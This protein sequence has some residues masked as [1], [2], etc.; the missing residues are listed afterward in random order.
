MSKNFLVILMAVVLLIS[1]SSEKKLARKASNAVSNTDYEKAI[2][3]YDE[4]LSKNKDSYIGNAGKGIVLSEYYEKHAQAIP[5]LQAALESSPSKTGKKI[6]YDLGKGFHYLGNYER[7]LYYFEKAS[8]FNEPG[9]ADYDV[10]LNKRIA[11]CKYALEHPEVADPQEASI[12]NLGKTIN[13]PDPEYGPV[14]LGT[15]M[16]FTSKRQDSPKEKRN[17]LDAKYFESIYIST[18]TQGIYSYPRRM[19]LSNSKKQLKTTMVNESILS[20]SP[21]GK[22]L[23]IF[24]KGKIFEADASDPSVNPEKI[25]HSISLAKTHAFITPDGKTLLF[26]AR[27][28]RDEYGTDIYKATKDKDGYWNDPVPLD[29]INTK[30]NDEGPFLSEDGTLYFASNGYPGYGGYDIYKTKFVNGQWTQPENLGQPIN[31]AADD[32]YLT[33]LPNSSYGYYSSGRMG[34]YGDMDV[35]QVHYVSKEIPKCQEENIPLSINVDKGDTIQRVY[36]FSAQMPEKYMNHVRSYTWKINDNVVGDKSNRWDHKFDQPGDY[37]VSVQTVIYCDS[38]PTLLAYCT[39]KQITVNDISFSTDAVASADPNN[40]VKGPSVG[41]KEN[42]ES[43]GSISLMNFNSSPGNFDLNRSGLSEEAKKQLDRNIDILKKNP[44]V[45]LIINGYADSRGSQEYNIY[46]SQQRANTV[47]QYFLKH[48]V[49][50]SRIVETKGY[51]ETFLTNN[52]AD[53]VDCTEEQHRANRRVEI[54]LITKDK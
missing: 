9:D 30:Y 2:S 21:D 3:Y 49:P 48:G 40:S 19:T 13:T 18:N 24:R 43:E 17:G 47:K 23:Y 15:N 39:E 6:N 54:K 31:S 29:A 28:P 20:V 36:Y 45:K 1:C 4:I 25:D 14:V 50:A 10:F 11:D 53:H 42:K 27:S 33:F 44:G 8:E 12:T 46:I 22:K 32:I 7:A 38:C 35:Y 26:S 37:K 16:M 52:C 51:G 41:E 5:Y 34:G